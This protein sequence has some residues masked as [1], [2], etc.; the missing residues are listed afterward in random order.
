MKAR[1]ESIEKLNH[2]KYS[3]INY[4]NIL[5]Q[6]L[7]YYGIICSTLLKYDMEK[8]NF[9][10]QRNDFLYDDTRETSILLSKLLNNDHGW[11]NHQSMVNLA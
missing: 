11:W 3:I 8:Y 10:L 6:K 9:N 2:K 7:N 1:N 5:H 4:N